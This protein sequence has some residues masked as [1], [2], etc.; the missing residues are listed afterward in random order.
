MV[1][2]TTL[3]VNDF[4]YP[5]F[6]IEG[7]G[8]KEEIVSMPGIYRYSLDLLLEEIQ[9][10]VDLGIKGFCVFPSLGDDKKD[11]YATEGSNKEGLYPKA[12]KA[13][14]TKFPEIAVMTDIAMDPYSCLLYT[15]PSPRDA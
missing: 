6:L 15:S 3:S 8:K 14:K 10:C 12:L 7:T 4:I 1:Q 9:E 11:K 2:E 5:V 13:I